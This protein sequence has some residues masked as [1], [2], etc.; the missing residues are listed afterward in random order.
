MLE[1]K[2]CGIFLSNV[3]GNTSSVLLQKWKQMEGGGGGFPRTVIPI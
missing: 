3:N 2:I 1:C